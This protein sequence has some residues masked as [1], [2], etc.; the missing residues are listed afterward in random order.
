MKGI[1]SNFKQGRHTVSKNQMVVLVPSVASRADAQK[2]V[3]KKVVW[4]SPAGKELSG[5]VASPHGNKG[6]LRVRFST[7]MP[8]QAIGHEV[9][10]SDS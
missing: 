3:G 7:G 2:L 4:K 6:A 9:I 1:I 10:L 8:G 5:V